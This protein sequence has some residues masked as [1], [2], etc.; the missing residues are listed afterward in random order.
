[1]STKSYLVQSAWSL[2]SQLQVEAPEAAHTY[3]T[4]EPF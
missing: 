1:M 3:P 2:A 4:N